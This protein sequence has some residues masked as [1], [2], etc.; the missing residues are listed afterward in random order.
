MTYIPAVYQVRKIMLVSDK[1]VGHVQ[2]RLILC[3]LNDLYA[4]FKR[5]YPTL[6]IRFTK[7]CS[8]RPKW[9]VY[10]GASGTHCVCTHHQN[11]VLLVNATY[12]MRVDLMEKIVCDTE[13]NECMVHRCQNCPESDVLEVFLKLKW[14]MKIRC[15][16][17]NGKQHRSTLI[18]WSVTFEELLI[19]CIDKLIGHS[20]IKVSRV[21][22]KT[23][24]G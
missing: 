4:E 12:K 3:N 7:F 5:I 8:L 13:N 22:P 18:T 1:G 19:L 9:C 2:K 21:L 6:K 17:N 11:V 10:A 24:E 14:M 20:Y 15:I 23:T 16:L